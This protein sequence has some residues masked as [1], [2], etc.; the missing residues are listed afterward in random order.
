MHLAQSSQRPW[1]TGFPVVADDDLVDL[2][3]RVCGGPAC[4]AMI[5]VRARQTQ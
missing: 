4:V 5:K 2:A 1:R 3:A